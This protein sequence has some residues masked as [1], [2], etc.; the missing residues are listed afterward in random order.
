MPNRYILGRQL[1]IRDGG[2]MKK[3]SKIMRFKEQRKHSKKIRR[4]ARVNDKLAN[5]LIE[6]EIMNTS[7]Y[8]QLKK[9]ERENV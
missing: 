6:R 4:Q 8:R 5:R 2:K 9:E 3:E 7:L 1:P